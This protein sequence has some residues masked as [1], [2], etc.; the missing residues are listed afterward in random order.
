MATRFH[1]AGLVVPNLEQADLFYRSFLEIEEAFRF[2]WDESD[3]DSVSQVINLTDSAA[4]AIMLKGENYNIE[5]F[6]Y[7]A[8]QQKGDP[9]ADRPCDPGIAHIAF[10][11]DDIQKACERFKSA[12]GTLHRDPVKLGTTWAIYGRDPFGNIVELM[13]PG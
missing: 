10:E 4:K 2:E 8:P 9:A 6:E 1:H 7:S 5:L 13:Q 11:F 12:G 3:S